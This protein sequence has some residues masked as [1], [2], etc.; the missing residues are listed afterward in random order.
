MGAVYWPMRAPVSGWPSQGPIRAPIG[1]RSSP[2]G[3][4][5]PLDLDSFQKLTR[6]R[7]AFNVRHPHLLR[8]WEAPCSFTKHLFVPEPIDAFALQTESIPRPLRFAIASIAKSRSTMVTTRSGKRQS[9]S[10]DVEVSPLLNGNGQGKKRG[11]GV[12]DG[13]SDA[14]AQEHDI[15]RQKVAEP[16]DK[17]RWRMKADGGRHTWHYLDDDEAAEKWPQSYAEKWYLGQD[18][19]CRPAL[20]LPMTVCFHSF[21]CADHDSLLRNSLLCRNQVPP[22]TLLAM[23]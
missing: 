21:R 18:L 4:Q 17:T 16:V 8:T 23:A 19:V 13:N 7:K 2:R 5:S 10:F 9:A 22:L 12:F 3:P 1:A 11:T 20:P 15:K 6:P 14:N